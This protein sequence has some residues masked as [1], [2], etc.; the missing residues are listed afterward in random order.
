MPLEITSKAP[1]H[2]QD[3]D[4]HDKPNQAGF[5]PVEMCCHSVP[6]RLDDAGAA[7]SQKRLFPLLSRR[8]NLCTAALQSSMMPGPNPGNLSTSSQLLNGRA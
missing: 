6:H 4:Q 7:T 1:E 8:S 2:R 3:G 5:A